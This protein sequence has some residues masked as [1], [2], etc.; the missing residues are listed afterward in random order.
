MHPLFHPLFVEFCA[1]FN[2]H[3]DYFECHEVLE[4]Y[5]KD[6]AP[7]ARLHP[8]VGYVQLATGLYHYRRGNTVGAARILA[9]AKAN[10]QLNSDSPFVDYIHLAQLLKDTEQALARIAADEPFQPFTIELTNPT[11]QQLVNA[12]AAS[13]PVQEK[14]YVHNK[15][16]LRDRSDILLARA[17]KMKRSRN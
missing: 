4:E 7:G 14:H 8:L 6:I 12:R 1:Y 16:M 17:E 13:L 2:T 9:K 15:H 3:E 10:L 5:W 11:L